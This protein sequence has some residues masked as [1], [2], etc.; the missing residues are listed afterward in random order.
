MK[1]YVII[2]TVP[3]IFLVSQP[4]SFFLF[5]NRNIVM[6][7]KRIFAKNHCLAVMAGVGENRPNIPFI[8]QQPAN[9]KG[10]KIKNTAG[11]NPKS[12]NSNFVL[13]K[14]L[15]AIEAR[16]KQPAV[17]NPDSLPPITN[18]PLLAKNKGKNKNKNQSCKKAQKVQSP[19]ENTQAKP[20]AVTAVDVPRN[21]DNTLLVAPATPA[22]AILTGTPATP[23]GK[24]IAMTA[25]TT[26][27]AIQAEHQAR[28]VNANLH[29]PS[30]QQPSKTI[31]AGSQSDNSENTPMQ[32]QKPQTL[33]TQK[34]SLRIKSTPPRFNPEQAKLLHTVA[35]ITGENFD[36]TKVAECFERL[37]KD[38][39][40]LFDYA[41]LSGKFADI[42]NHPQGIECLCALPISWGIGLLFQYR[43]E[44]TTPNIF[45]ADYL[46]TFIAKNGR[47]PFNFGEFMLGFDLLQFSYFDTLGTETLQRHRVPMAT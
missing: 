28:K 8:P 23:V 37:N 2:L 27:V 18:T 14:S 16:K 29:S 45:I 1:F 34:V 4:L 25:S 3:L 5:L 35:K 7:T 43:I 31:S 38:E 22:P 36:K 47:S 42:L 6:L 40:N 39:K 19:D 12:T 17:G 32:K 24:Q 33:S 15:N 46:R 44:I 21:Q 26:S 20:T 30:S 11:I 13:E 9:R 41:R 10:R